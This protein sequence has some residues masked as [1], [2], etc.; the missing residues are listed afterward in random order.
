[1]QYRHHLTYLTLT[2]L[3]AAFLACCLAVANHVS[4]A[5]L[6]DA[7]LSNWG[8][9]VHEAITSYPPSFTPLAIA[10]VSTVG[11]SYF[12][13]GSY[14]IPYI[15]ARGVG[16]VSVGCGNGRVDPGEQCDDGNTVNGRW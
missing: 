16:V 14:G 9:S 12:P 15:I 13:D 1:M 6:T 7:S 11:S 8:C 5:G 2:A 3:C 10:S 4:L